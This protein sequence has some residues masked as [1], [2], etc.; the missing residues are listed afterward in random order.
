MNLISQLQCSHILVSIYITPPPPPS[1]HWTGSLCNPDKL[2]LVWGLLIYLQSFWGHLLSVK[3]D[4]ASPDFS[5][6]SLEVCT[7]LLGSRSRRDQWNTLRWRRNA[8]FCIS[9]YM[10]TYTGISWFYLIVNKMSRL[11]LS[12]RGS[13][14]CPSASWCRGLQRCHK[15]VAV[16][17]LWWWRQSSVSQWP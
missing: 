17:L 11:N 8:Y 3:R 14:K 12:Q 2:T 15:W 9:G 16:V 6:G 13:M 10:Y 4:P 1:V 5:K 7:F